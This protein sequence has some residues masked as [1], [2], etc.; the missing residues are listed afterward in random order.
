MGT[1]GGEGEG[2]GDGEG[3]GEWDGE[4]EGDGDGEGEG[5]I[6]RE[7]EKERKREKREKRDTHGNIFPLLLSFAPAPLILQM[8]PHRDI[9]NRWQA[10]GCSE[11]ASTTSTLIK[12]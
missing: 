8:A 7:R 4:G 12:A 11:M 3:E 6:G 9:S 1:G 10:T 5:G 2:E